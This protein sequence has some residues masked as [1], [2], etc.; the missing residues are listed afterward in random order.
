MYRSYIVHDVCVV[1]TLFIIRMM[2]VN[3][4]AFSKSVYSKRLNSESTDVQNTSIEVST[5]T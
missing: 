4:D 5:L 3:T 2:M 1:Q